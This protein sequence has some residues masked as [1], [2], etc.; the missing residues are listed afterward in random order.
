[1]T[2][3]FL[4]LVFS[5]C[6]IFGSA[7]TKTSSSK[8]TLDFV[9]STKSYV[10][11]RA[12]DFSGGFSAVQG[13]VRV[14]DNQVTSFDIVISVNSLKLELPGMTKHALSSDYFDANQFPT[15]TFFGDQIVTEQGKSQV[16]GK[17]K[18]KDVEQNAVIPFEVL[19]LGKNHIIIQANFK[20]SRPTY[21]IG[22]EGEV[23]D[24]VEI[25]TQI[26]ANR[27]K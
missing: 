15:I 11:L 20:I 13:R 7:Q 9:F 3:L 12:E 8:D 16:S 5:Q 21:G 2:R 14:C 24:T 23:S 6:C 25:Q 17:L 19:Q 4:L 27:K 1:M 22:P 10:T 26:V 18:A